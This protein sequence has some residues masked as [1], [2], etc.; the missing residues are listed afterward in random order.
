MKASRLAEQVTQATISMRSAN[1]DLR[2]RILEVRNVDVRSAIAVAL[3]FCGTLCI[4]APLGLS[5]FMIHLESSGK[6][7]HEN[8]PVAIVF[9]FVVI[10]AG[11]GMVLVAVIAA[12]RRPKSG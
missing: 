2:F 10:L 9:G 11:I 8:Q 6:A 5:A 12:F 3:I 1:L 4:M 7:F